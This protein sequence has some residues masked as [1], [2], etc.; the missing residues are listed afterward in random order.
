[1]LT[2]QDYLKRIAEGSGNPI[3]DVIEAHKSSDEYKTAVIADEYDAQRNVT[4]RTFTRM[5][6][7]SNGI[8]SVDFT[9]S[10]NRICSNFFSRLNTQRV[11]YSLGN[12][13]SFVQPGEDTPEDTTKEMLGANFDFDLIQ[14]G[15]KA[16]EH[17]VTFLFWNHDRM[18]SFPITE[19]A[20]LW[21]EQTGELRAGIRFWRID[22]NHPLMVE[23]YEQDG[24]TY[25]HTSGT[26]SR[27]LIQDGER[28]AYLERVVSVPVDGPR[29]VGTMNYGTL[30]VIPMFGNSHKQS[31]LVGMRGA[32]DAYDLI[33]SGFANDL[34]DCAEIYWLTTNSGGMTDAELGQFRDRLKLLHIANIDSDNGSGVTPYT[35]EPPYQARSLFLQELKSDIYDGFGALDVHAVAAGATNDH[36]DAAYQPLDENAADFEHWV[37]EAVHQ[38]LLLQGVDDWPVFKR[39]RISNQLEQVQMI[40]A[41]AQWLDTPTI[42]RKLPNVTSEEVRAIIE[43]TEMEAAGVF[44]IGE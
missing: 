23:L 11:M 15:R 38:L 32:I 35:Q 44:G 5:L 2:Y 30:P 33:R 43:G 3:M 42:L 4:I 24:I 26:N 9:A 22:S 14:A 29:V 21:D 40:V 19:F 28:T 34:T 17:G 25:F 12:G 16:V 37:G 6:Y 20:P 1:M 41:E 39:H 31:T 7:S 10:N 8:P 36:I 27:E 13:V 18:H